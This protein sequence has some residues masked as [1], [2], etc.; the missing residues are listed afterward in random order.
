MAH[1]LDGFVKGMEREFDCLDKIS[2]K[3]WAILFLVLTL[4]DLSPTS[5]R[6]GAQ[7]T[8]NGADAAVES[9]GVLSAQSG[10]LLA[11]IAQAK[12]QIADS[13][14]SKLGLK[15]GPL[16]TTNTPPMTNTPPATTNSPL[17]TTSTPPLTNSLP[18]TT[19]SQPA[20]SVV[21]AAGG[22]G[23]S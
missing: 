17:A 7:G 8:P 4:H 22:D 23:T 15:K 1:R 2:L 11:D 19:S 16:A 6:V 10:L 5:F 21:L 12:A 13:I 14:L 9:T 20:T 18:A 3:K